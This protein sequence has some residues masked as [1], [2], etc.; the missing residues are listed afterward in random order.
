[1]DGFVREKAYNLKRGLIK[2][3]ESLKFIEGDF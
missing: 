1:M 2:E 3:R